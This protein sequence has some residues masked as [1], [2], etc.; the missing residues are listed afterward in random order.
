MKAPNGYGSISKLSGKR[1]RPFWVRITTGWELHNDKPKQLYKTIGYYATRKEALLA[2]AEYHA[3]PLDDLT[4]KDIT[5]KEVYE[6]WSPKYFEKKPASKGANVAAFK[7]CVA[8]YDMKM[9]DIKTAHV[10]SVLDSI[11]DASTSTQSNTKTVI[12]RCFNYCIE[13]DILQKNYA[14]FATI[15]V[16]EVDTSEKFFTSDEIKRILDNL[17]FTVKFPRGKT[18]YFNLN[19]TDTIVI[20]LYSGLRI[21]ELLGIKIEDI[22]LEEKYI[23]VNGTKT[24]NAKRI[25]PIHDK[26]IEIIKRN[27]YGEYLISYPDGKAIAYQTYLRSFYKLYMEHL[28]LDVT[29]H[30]TRHTFIT[31]AD[32]YGVN[33]NALKKIVGHSNASI[34]EHYTH[35]ELSDL[36]AEINKIDC[37]IPV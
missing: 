23:N 10:Q 16:K 25:L 14:E 31:L 18:E 12:S 6:I 34:T 3:N 17:D 30:A 27:M 29:P 15:E 36:I 21:G 19:L 1:R 24:K 11:A 5:F 8:L 32:K 13:N 9:R 33:Q 7:K 2:L 35:K 28:N 20:M 26:I 37:H 22:H 4:N